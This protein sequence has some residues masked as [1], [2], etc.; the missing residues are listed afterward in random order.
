MKKPLKKYLLLGILGVSFSQALAEEFKI[1]DK[2]SPVLEIRP[3][4]EFVSDKN[5]SLKDANALTT[6][7]RIGAKLE[8]LFKVKNLNA[9]LEE[10]F[11]GAI[12]DKYSPE[13]S[14]YDSVADPQNARLTQA[15]ISYKLNKTTFIAGRKFVIID[16]HRFIGNVNWRQMPQSFGVLAISDNT[17]KN[18][19]ILIAGIYER[20]GIVD[21]LNADWK[22]D[23]MPLI[24]DVNYK[25]SNLLK[26][27]GFAYLIT[28]IHN[29]YG[30]KLSGSKY[31]SEDFKL[32]YLL[33]YAKQTDPYKIDNVEKKPDIDTKY[34]RL[35]VGLNYKGLIGNFE[36]TR[37]GDKN[38]RDA[39]FSTPL[40]TLHKFDGWSDVLLEGEEKGF[41]YG[42]DEF[43][44]T[45]GYK[46]KKFGKFLVNYLLFNSYKSQPVGDKIGDEIDLL[47]TKKLTKHLSFLA[48]SA[49]YNGKNGYYQGGNLIG[50]KDTTKYW[51]Q[52]DYTY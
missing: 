49:F 26:I 40:A 30:V 37:F 8:K 28:N 38:G 22:M 10:T 15:Y 6:R 7:I 50:A 13:K 25:F 45:L 19:N 35:N 24:F 11:V 5:N 52:F 44:F 9:Y 34:Y 12:V 27:K 43:K 3:R 23:K 36:F 48:K 21:K 31:I 16:D 47:Y 46:N 29:T 39:G 51:I 2:V 20:K 41:D 42:L 4:Y 18:L 14:N 1:I 33:E 17:I 32:K